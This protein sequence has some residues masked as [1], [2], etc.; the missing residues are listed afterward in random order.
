MT[1]TTLLKESVKLAKNGKRPKA[2]QPTDLPAGALINRK[3]GEYDFPKKPA[4]A[5]DI[6]YRARKLRL[7]LQHRVEKLD[8][9][10]TAIENYFI[11]TLPQSNATGIS[12]QVATVAILP[13]P[14]PVVE[15]DG[16]W[17]KLYA[18]IVK[19]KAFELLQRRLSEGAVKE[20]L[21]DGQR[22]PGVTI[23]N[24]KKVSCTAI[25]GKR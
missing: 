5:A 1:L 2:T 19:N 7:D 11:D 17:D 10:E 12:G 16:G 20:R 9:L 23:F 22:I 3:T 14:I 4:L 13:R 25:K 8:K 24:A 6:L 18:F 15:S 21:D